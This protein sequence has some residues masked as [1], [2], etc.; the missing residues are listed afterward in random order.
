MNQFAASDI[1]IIVIKAINRVARQ[2]NHN[3]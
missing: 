3:T 1:D 2:P